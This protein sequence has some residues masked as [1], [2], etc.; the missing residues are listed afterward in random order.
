MKMKIRAKSWGVAT[1]LL[2]VAASAAEGQWNDDDRGR[3]VVE[4][5]VVW[6]GGAL[7]GADPQGEFGEVVS[8]GFGLSG[9]GSLPL[10]GDGALRLRAEGGFIIYGHERRGVCFPPPVGCRIDLELTTSNS[11]F[12]LGIGPE[13]ALPGR[14]E[15]YVNATGGF[16]YFA[17]TSSLSGTH[18]SESFAE[19]RNFSDFVGALAFGGGIRAGVSGGRTPVWLDLGVRYHRNGVAEYLR[20]GDIV[21]EPD[22]SI[23]IYPNRSQANLVTYSLGVSVGIPRGGDDERRRG[24]R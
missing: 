23:T 6:V 5:P 1:I 22:G 20:E 10:A 11:I 16:S 19:T 15:P 21:D 14:V 3:D 8:Q 18:D 4:R 17:T 24:R 13:L 2:A 12:F 9:H 7:L